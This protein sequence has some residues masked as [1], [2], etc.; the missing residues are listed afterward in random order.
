MA[1]GGEGREQ[2]TRVAAEEGTHGAG[3]GGEFGKIMNALCYG[4]PVDITYGYPV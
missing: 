2:R 4:I 1:R 3:G